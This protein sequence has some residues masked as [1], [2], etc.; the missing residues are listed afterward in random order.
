MGLF[1]PTAKITPREW[2]K[3]RDRLDDRGLS[4]RNI[5]DVEAVMQQALHERGRSWSVDKKEAEEIITYLRRE[6]G[7]HNLSEREIALV[8]EVFAEEL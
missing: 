7:S 4:K 8:E 2:R 6:L 1:S 3:I 5:D